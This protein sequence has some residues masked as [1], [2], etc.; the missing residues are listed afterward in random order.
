MRGLLS[1]VESSQGSEFFLVLF[2]LMFL[3]LLFW[4]FMPSRKKR[5]EQEALIPLQDGK[6]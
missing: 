2:C 3:G 4:V 6:E 5:Y 1:F